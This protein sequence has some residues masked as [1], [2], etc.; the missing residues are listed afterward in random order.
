MEEGDDVPHPGQGGQL[1]ADP[2]DLGVRGGVGEGFRKP[3][4]NMHDRYARR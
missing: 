3:E 1:D 2:P 4:T